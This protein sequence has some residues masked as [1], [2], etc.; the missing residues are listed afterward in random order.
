MTR[1]RPWSFSCSGWTSES[2]VDVSADSLLSCLTPTFNSLPHHGRTT[3]ICAEPTSLK[4][5][6]PSFL[7]KLAQQMEEQGPAG[8]AERQVAKL[9]EDDE[10]GVGEPGGD[11]SWL[12]L[13]L[14]LFESVDEFN[15][16]EEPYALAMVL[17]GLDA[18]R[19]GEMRLACA[20]A[21]DQDDIVSVFQ[22]LAAM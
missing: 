20:G 18:D 15:G 22:E 6:V 5:A 14:L 11:L 4:R 19:G 8:G 16:G 10:I 9:V 17:D 21:A 7:R 13:K 1:R 12:A 2:T 3:A